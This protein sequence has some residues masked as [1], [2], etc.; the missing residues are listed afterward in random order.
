[1]NRAVDRRIS[2]RL[3][4]EQN[5]YMRNVVRIQASL[6]KPTNKIY[7]GSSRG[8]PYIEIGIEASS[9]KVRA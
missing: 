7:K 1:M 5:E 3:V 4:N 8:V 2:M 9:I 6:E